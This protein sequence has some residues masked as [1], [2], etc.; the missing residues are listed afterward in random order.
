M[1]TTIR[2]KTTKSILTIVSSMTLLFSL[3]SCQDY[4][5]VQPEDKLSG[6]QVYRD[7]YDADAAVCYS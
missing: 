1:I 4:L 6:D 2:K 5:D 3:G 7:I